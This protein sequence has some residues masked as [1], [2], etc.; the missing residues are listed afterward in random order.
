MRIY[1][2]FYCV[3]L[4]LLF[5]ISG[6]AQ[7]VEPDNSLPAGLPQEF[8]FLSTTKTSTFEKELNDAAQ[9]GFRFLRL[10]KALNEGSLG[11]LL[12]RDQMAAG[13]T[14]KARYEYKVLATNRISTMKKELEAAAA[15]GY[16]FLGIT[17]ENKII[18]FTYPETIVV[19]ERPTGKIK[20]RFD[21]KFIS[22]QREKTAQKEMDAAV[23]E[24]YVPVEMIF[25]QDTKATTMLL[26]ASQFYVTIILVRDTENPG[27]EMGKQEYRLLSTTRV[28]TMEKEMNQLAKEGFQFH[29]SALGGYNILSR[30]LKGTSARYEYLLP[31]TRRTGTMQ[32]ELTDMGVQGYR[33]MGFSTGAGGMVSVMEREIGE[34]RKSGKYEYKFLAT[35]LEETT[36]KEMNEALASG[37]K[38]LEIS[39]LGEKLIVLGRKAPEDKAESK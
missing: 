34:G 24:G 20:R 35:T 31:A 17:T 27:S 16:E 21:Y 5:A 3:A 6:Q 7:T 9:K 39:T 37:F 38:F 4:A 29:L 32:K 30:P 19:L 14:P 25:G 23:S 10:S 1:L 15:E 8:Q 33:F 36:Q 11:G 22:A 13:A 2:S 18:P 28:K 12:S 26:G